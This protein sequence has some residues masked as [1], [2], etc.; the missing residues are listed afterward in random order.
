MKTLRQLT[1]IYFYKKV[2]EKLR[3]SDSDIMK[4]KQ[5]EE[6]FTSERKGEKKKRRKMYKRKGEDWKKMKK[7]MFD[8]NED[9]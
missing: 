3:K 6:K 8:K 5:S 2:W 7:Y 9:K 1:I 4:T